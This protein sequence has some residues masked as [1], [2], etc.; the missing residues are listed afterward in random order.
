MIDDIKFHFD[1]APFHQWMNDRQIRMERAA[2][3][4]VREGGRVVKREARANAPV[5]SDTSAIRYRAWRK[6]GGQESGPVV[7]LLKNSIR[8]ARRLT[9]DGPF[10]TLKVGPR[11][12]RVHLYAGKEEEREGYMEAGYQAAE[13]MM[14]AVAED[15]YGRVWKGI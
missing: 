11:G 10:W 6:G 12:Q 13:A 4:T 2:M 8:P 1:L 14:A 7:G 9:R 3:W 15:S 5:L